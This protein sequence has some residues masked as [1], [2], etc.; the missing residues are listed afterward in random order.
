MNDDR[1]QQ[2]LAAERAASTDVDVDARNAAVVGHLRT[3]A[4][5]GVV[6]AL[7]ASAAAHAATPAASLATGSVAGLGL[8][9]VAAVVVVTTVVGVGVGVGA[10]VLR[11]PATEPV[12]ASAATAQTS[13]VPLPAVRAEDAPPPADD[14]IAVVDEGGTVEEAAAPTVTSTKAERV[15]RT[16]A[17]GPVPVVAAGDDV[18]APTPPAAPSSLERYDLAEAALRAGRFDEA[19]TSFAWW[20]NDHPD[21][22]LRPEASLS[23]IEALYRAQRFDELLAAAPA[24]RVEV[25]AS[26]RGDVERLRAEALVHRQRCDEAAVAFAEARRAHARDLDDDDVS[27]AVSACRAASRR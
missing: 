11:R 22:V 4:G 23:L 6:G 1:L 9:K 2:L 15:Q 14:I 16:P 19:A 7:T 3:I 26:R 20:L 10:V 21:D 8:A 13:P 12:A 25:D 5:A 18:S 24:A 17:D 27:A